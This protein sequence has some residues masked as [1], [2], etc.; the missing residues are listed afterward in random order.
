MIQKLK[1]AKWQNNFMGENSQKDGLTLM[2]DDAFAVLRQSWVLRKDPKR[3][4]IISGMLKQIEG[5]DTDV[6]KKRVNFLLSEA[7]RKIKSGAIK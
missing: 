5:E 4:E 3:H 6:S 7:K 2:L 1:K